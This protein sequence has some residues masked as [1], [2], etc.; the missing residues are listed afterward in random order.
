MTVPVV[1]SPVLNG[2]PVID[3]A[4]TPIADG[5]VYTYLAGTSTPAATYQ[6]ADGDVVNANPIVLTTRGYLLKPLWLLYAVRYR[7]VITRADGV[8]VWEIDGITGSVPGSVTTFPASAD[9]SLGGHRITNLLNAAA[10]T[11]AITQAGG[12]ARYLRNPATV[13][14]GMASQRITNLGAAAADGDLL[15]RASG[16]ARY[17]A[18]TGDGSQLTGLT[19]P[20]FLFSVPGDITGDGTLTSAWS[21]FFVVVNSASAVVLT[22]RDDVPV[23]WWCI[24]IRRGSGAVTLRRQSTGTM[25]GSASDI[26]LAAQW[27]VAHLV[28]EAAGNLSVIRMA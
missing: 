28:K 9:V 27:N 2:I 14:L 3:A 8:L 17:Q 12:D 5:L 26:S 19:T 11:D 6:D 22:I 4:G 10:G 18:T 16:D 15:N 25:N 1:L 13:G 23:D 24:V 7:L 20:Q 21:G